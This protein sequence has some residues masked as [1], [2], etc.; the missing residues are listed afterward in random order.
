MR[1]C[2]L[3]TAACLV[4]GDWAFDVGRPREGL[5]LLSNDRWV[6]SECF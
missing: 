1:A 4:R 2:P 5:Q 6:C 3:G